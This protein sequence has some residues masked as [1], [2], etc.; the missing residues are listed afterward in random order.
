VKYAH[1]GDGGRVFF[2]FVS[3]WDGTLFDVF[4]PAGSQR[5]FKGYSIF[6][7]FS[8]VFLGIVER[9]RVFEGMQC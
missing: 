2:V 5:I 9:L 3:I 1:Q 7:I 8:K 4:V 6:A